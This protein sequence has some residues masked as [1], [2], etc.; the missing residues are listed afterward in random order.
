MI[1]QLPNMAVL[2]CLVSD[3][4]SGRTIGLGPGRTPLMAYALN[5]FDTERLLEGML[6]SA[7]ILFA[8]GA[9]EVHP[10]VSGAPV[11]YSAQEAETVLGGRWPA[12]ALRLTAYHPMGTARMGA[13][14][15]GVLDEWG[16]VR[17]RERLV[18][19][20]ASVFPTSLGVNPQ[21][22]IMAFASR[23]AEGILQRW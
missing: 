4:S 14:E 20:D 17:G 3:T 11:M 19:P 13:D 9:K 10:M 8:A 22:T 18:V 6:L 5:R 2:G 12:A 16:R 7:R 23:A 21:V 15:G 1:E